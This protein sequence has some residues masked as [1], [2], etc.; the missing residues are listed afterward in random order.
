MPT[1]HL[2]TAADYVPS[3]TAHLQ[4]TTSLAHSLPRPSDIA[5]HRSVDPKLAVRLDEASGRVWGVLQGLLTLVDGLKEEASSSKAGGATK[6]KKRVREEEGL[7]DEFERDVGD[8]VDGLLERAVSRLDY[9]IL[10]GQ[11]SRHWNVLVDRGRAGPGIAGGICGLAGGWREEPLELN[12]REL[13]LVLITTSA[14]LIPLYSQ[15]T[16]LDNYTGKL[17]PPSIPII[18]TETA[19]SKVSQLHARPVARRRT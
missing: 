9:R 1:P 14:P 4:Q 2:P 5:F 8:A 10:S 13:L 19:R 3:L 18:P 11:T 15:D 16:C 12:I 7:V 6:S 17:P